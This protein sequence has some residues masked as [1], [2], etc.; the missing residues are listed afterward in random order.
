MCPTHWA[1]DRRER[2]GSP[3]VERA[4]VYCGD[5][6]SRNRGAAVPLHRDCKDKVPLWVREGR[7]RHESRDPE[8]R[9][10]RAGREVAILSLWQGPKACVDQ[11]SDLRAGV[12]DGD[13][14]LFLSAVRAKSV[15]SED[16]CWEWSGRRNG[17]YPCA[18]IAGK[19]V[20]VHRLVLEMAMG[21]PLGVMESHHK[22]ANSVCVNPDHLQMV[23][24]YD[25]IAEM[26]ARNSLEARVRELE[27][28]VFVLDPENDVLNRV[29]VTTPQEVSV[30]C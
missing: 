6:L 12:E 22:C 11:R 15:V 23:T 29:G 8:V 30:V 24:Q 18:T 1:R 25:N 16:G 27:A 21:K 2:L 5:P 13:Y 14:P 7:K 19:R 3:H 4:C 10:M 26:R 17:G 28:A 9:A 20:S